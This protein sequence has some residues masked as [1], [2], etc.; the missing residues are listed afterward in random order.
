MQSPKLQSMPMCKYGKALKENMAEVNSFAEEDRETRTS[1]TDKGEKGPSI[2][3][4]HASYNDYV[5]SPFPL[6]RVYN[7]NGLVTLKKG[8]FLHFHS[9]TF[10]VGNAKQLAPRLPV[11]MR[12]KQ[13]DAEMCIAKIRR[14]QGPGLLS[15]SRN[16]ALKEWPTRSLRADSRE[17]V[18][19]RHQ[20]GTKI[21]FVPS[22]RLSTQEIQEMK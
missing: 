10:W 17:V 2:N 5:T 9:L 13:R 22:P 21:I 11:A 3:D 16:G 1:Y 14:Y 7:G 15:V 6:Q 8:Q 12:D 19:P 4:D 18:S 20:A